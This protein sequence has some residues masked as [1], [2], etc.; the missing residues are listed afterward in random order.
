MLHFFR[1][2]KLSIFISMLTIALLNGANAI[3]AD[4][5]KG[6]AHQIAQNN[7]SV[8]DSS[9]RVAISSAEMNSERKEKLPANDNRIG[10]Y[11]MEDEA[12]SGYYG[13]GEYG[14]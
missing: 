7:N 11:S 8:F 12:M 14:D 2:T 6:D 9:A 5:A 4:S 1:M 10:A 13:D 3:A